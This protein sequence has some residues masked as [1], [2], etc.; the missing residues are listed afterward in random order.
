MPN[1]P[2]KKN[3]SPQRRYPDE[4]RDRAVKMVRDLTTQ[5]PKDR[6]VFNRVS[7]QLGVGTQSLR[8]WVAR[9]ETVEGLRPSVSEFEATELRELRKEVKELRRANDILRAAA[10]FFGAE[11]DRQPRR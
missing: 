11:L 7:R 10:T 8:L 2:I 1:M 3:V 5:D 9:A 4:L 6:G